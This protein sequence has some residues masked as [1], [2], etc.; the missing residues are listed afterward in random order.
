MKQKSKYIK[1]SPTEYKKYLLNNWRTK[2]DKV[3]VILGLVNVAATLPQLYEM[4]SSKDAGGVSI[5]TWSY[6]V[7]FTAILLVYSFSIKSKPMIIMYTGNTIVYTLV[8]V[9]AVVLKS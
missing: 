8:L 3:I 6:Y 1:I 2:F 5:I 9:S 4:W 7:V